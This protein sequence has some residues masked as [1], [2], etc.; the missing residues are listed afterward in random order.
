MDQ[1]NIYRD[2]DNISICKY[3][4]CMHTDDIYREKDEI[5][6]YFYTYKLSNTI[7]SRLHIH[8]AL[9]I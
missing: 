5:N 8:I 7:Y 3:D 9:V 1:D 6:V 4:T 2:I